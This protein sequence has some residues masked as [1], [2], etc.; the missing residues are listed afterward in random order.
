MILPGNHSSGLIVVK[1]ETEM[2][3]QVN[4][5]LVIHI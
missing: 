3:S 5:S 2:T 4:W 1:S